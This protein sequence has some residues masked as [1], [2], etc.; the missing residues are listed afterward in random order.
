MGT[1]HLTVLF[2]I[3]ETCP[4]S[5]RKTVAVRHVAKQRPELNHIVCIVSE[6]D[7]QQEC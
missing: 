7:V 1:V 2:K 6:D 4:S 5:S 3:L